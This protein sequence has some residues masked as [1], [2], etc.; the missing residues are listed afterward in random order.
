MKIAH[1]KTFRSGNSDAVRLP[2]EVSLGPDIEVEIV[3]SGD[4]LTIRPKARRSM[5]E[6]VE[7]LRKLPRPDGVQKRDRI[8]FP[9]R[10][11]L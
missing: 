3:R 8:V 9:K 5:R 1:S 2:R 10:R 4:V 6:L 7:A 11:G